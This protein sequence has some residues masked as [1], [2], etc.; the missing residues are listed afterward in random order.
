MCWRLGQPQAAPPGGRGAPLRCL[1]AHGRWQAAGRVMTTRRITRVRLSVRCHLE[2]GCEGVRCA[3]RSAM[4]APPRA[5]ASPPRASARLVTNRTGHAGQGLL[6]GAG[7]STRCHRRGSEEGV[8]GRGA[9]P[10]RGRRHQGGAATAA[11]F[12]PIRNACASI[13]SGMPL[14]ALAVGG[15]CAAIERGAGNVVSAASCAVPR[16]WQLGSRHAASAGHALTRR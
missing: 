3:G 10:L 7:C 12:P 4:Q 1:P 15:V 2:G 16:P 9:G 6:Q 13:E 8:S 11:A 5:T 14:A